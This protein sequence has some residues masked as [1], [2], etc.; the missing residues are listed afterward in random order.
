MLQAHRTLGAVFDVFSAMNE[1]LL[2]MED[3]KA[4]Y[5][6]LPSDEDTQHMV[7]AINHA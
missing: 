5:N 7:T 3:P 1:H 4:A 6:A 2:H